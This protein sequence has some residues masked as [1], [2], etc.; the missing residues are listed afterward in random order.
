MD[1]SQN[2]SQG[3]EAR[4]SQAWDGD[5][6]ATADEAELSAGDDAEAMDTSDPSA[7]AGVA[8]APAAAPGPSSTAPAPGPPTDLEIPIATR[9]KCWQRGNAYDAKVI[10]VRPGAVFLHYMGYKKCH[11]EWVALDSGRLV[12][13]DWMTAQPNTPPPMAAL[14]RPPADPGYSLAVVA[15]N[16]AMAAA[17][18]AA[19]TV[20][21][22]PEAAAT[23]AAATAGGLVLTTTT[24]T[25]TSASE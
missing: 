13:P 6:L 17:N 15:A 3:T 18:E 11:E 25:W 5:L 22:E 24:T 12:L 23:A 10:K 1:D 14:V 4:N 2:S 9:L 7:N 21:P 19:T 16:R 20:T 8:S